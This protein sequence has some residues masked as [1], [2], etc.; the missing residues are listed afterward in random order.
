M[1]GVAVV[2]LAGLAVGATT[3]PASADNGCSGDAQACVVIT[4]GGSTQSISGST[5]NADVDVSGKIYEIR[6]RA[7]TNYDPETGESLNALLNN[8]GINLPASGHLDVDVGGPTP[9]QIPAKG[10][11]PG[12]GYYVNNLQPIVFSNGPDSV[13]FVRPLVAGNP[14]DENE[15]D[16]QAPHN[17][18]EDISVLSGPILHV[19]LQAPHHV[20][21]GQQ[22]PLSAS[23]S[24]DPNAGFVSYTFT[25]SDTGQQKISPGTT[26]YTFN[27]CGVTQVTVEA[28]GDDD[29]DGFATG[30]VN[31]GHYKNCDPKPSPSQSPSPGGNH[32]KPGSTSGPSP[33][34]PGTTKG[35]APGSTHG[36]G[37]AGHHGKGRGNGNGLGVGL[38]NGL[39][40][41]PLPRLGHQNVGTGL[42]PQLGT[43]PDVATAPEVQGQLVNAGHALSL[44][45]LSSPTASQQIQAAAVS[46]EDPWRL[47]EWVGIG[48]AVLLFAAGAA[49]ELRNR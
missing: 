21:Q 40:N 39:P 22:A 48:A 8:A 29:S 10:V 44:A 27:S 16:D 37:K 13:G 26:N 46:P 34:G 15:P 24:G 30:Y 9:A 32:G 19:A 28:Q 14:N 47:P 33:S 5:V 20:Q 49:R 1:T 3:V 43:P 35:S 25:F 42:A 4:Q 41:I 2:G 31:V 18:P 23:E 38:G 6:G 45:A 7:G 17:G 36:S 11:D 12:S